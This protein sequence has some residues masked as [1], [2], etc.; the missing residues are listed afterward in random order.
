MMTTS[1][2]IHDGFYQEA[3]LHPDIIQNQI[4]KNPIY[5][6]ILNKYLYLQKI[7]SSIPTS[8]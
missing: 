3:P 5:T 6:F 1:A 4:M 8:F 2:Y 7:T